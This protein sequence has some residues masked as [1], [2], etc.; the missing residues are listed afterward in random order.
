[1][2][3]YSSSNKPLEASASVLG[4]CTDVIVKWL[5]KNM[6]TL[7]AKK[8]KVMLA[9]KAGVLGGI[10]LPPLDEA[11]LFLANLKGLTTCFTFSRST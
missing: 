11:I 8:I 3:P 10:G 7:G 5:R 9:V 1:M 2:Q 6:L 4:L